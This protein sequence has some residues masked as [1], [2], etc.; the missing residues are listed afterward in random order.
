MYTDTTATIHITVTGGASIASTNA[1]TTHTY[2][3]PVTDVL[4]VTTVEPQHYVLH[5]LMGVAIL[6]GSVDKQSG[7]DMKEIPA[8][9]YLLQL[10]DNN[11]AREVQR[12]V[13]E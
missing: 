9:V 3:N 12:I 10:T 7:I 11:G 4:H 13:K 8:G 1:T 6:Q 5:N 2:P